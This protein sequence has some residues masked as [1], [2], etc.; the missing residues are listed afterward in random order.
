MSTAM[1]SLFRPT[2][3]SSR[4]YAAFGIF[5][6]CYF[7]IFMLFL[8]ITG[9]YHLYPKS[10]I[11]NSFSSA[12]F[13]ALPL[14]FLPRR[15]RMLA[16]AIMAIISIFFFCQY[17]Y[18][19]IFGDF[20]TG[21][22]LL[23][24]DLTDSAFTESA[25]SLVS[26]K[27]LTLF[28]PAFVS[29]LTFLLL[30][31]SMDVATSRWTKITGLVLFLLMPAMTYGMTLRRNYKWFNAIN[32]TTMREVLVGQKTLLNY[33]DCTYILTRHLGPVFLVYH[34]CATLHASEINLTAEERAR[35]ADRIST[36]PSG[37]TS[38]ATSSGKS[39]IL[40]FVESFNSSVLDIPEAREVMPVI[41]SLIEDS[42]TVTARRVLTQVSHGESSDGQFI[43]T[44]GL[45]P[46][47]NGAFVSHFSASDYPSLPKALGYKESAEVIC[48]SGNVWQHTSTSKSYGYDRLYEMSVDNA[49]PDRDAQVLTCAACVIDS[50]TPPYML[51]VSTIGMHMPYL[52]TIDATQPLD[53]SDDRWRK[54][55]TR[56]LNYII[57]THEFDRAL[58]VF[59]DSVNAKSLRA[60]VE[61][62]VIAIIGDHATPRNSLPAPLHTGY[63]PFIVCNSGHTLQYDTPVGQ[64][65]VFPTLL[66][67]M[68][69]GTSYILPSTGRPY[70]GLGQS[71][72]S[73]TPPV[74][75]VSA[76]GSPAEG[77]TDI[78][79]KAA[80]WQL[81]DSL[82][83][84]RFFNR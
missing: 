64:I 4:L 10:A 15:L 75:A 37:N 1:A 47:R 74:G 45:L 61:P 27:S 5:T 18:Y 30:R 79:S 19:L 9:I 65:D 32:K 76:D 60:G 8:Y 70:R 21:A 41:T 49:L 12:L 6:A 73:D 80:M 51:M 38:H 71:I 24:S 81:S 54:Y 42:G 59:V 11:F 57:A 63:V 55:G 39:L 33:P 23:A 53:T 25:L 43:I 13:F 46:F 28:I 17:L 67:I 31:K 36:P 14:L 50:M 82:I 72:L 7:A 44:T 78:E 58:G 69:V 16:P 26:L 35:L 2:L 66:D 84:A 52:S 40:I 56:C 3:H 20:F 83:R 48:E 77:T 34:F 22:A 29:I 62:P 68:G